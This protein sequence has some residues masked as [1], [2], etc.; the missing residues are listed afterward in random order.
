[1][2]EVLLLLRS[3][4]VTYL[5]WSCAPCSHFVHGVYDFMW[6]FIDDILTHFFWDNRQYFDIFHIILGVTSVFMAFYFWGCQI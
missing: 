1:M 3:Y 6:Q 5:F 4:C 2:E